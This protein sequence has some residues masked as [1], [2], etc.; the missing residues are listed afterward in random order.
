MSSLWAF[1]RDRIAAPFALIFC[2]F[3]IVAIFARELAPLD[4][5]ETNLAQGLLP[6]SAEHW[7]GTDQFGR[8][9]FSRVILAT[10]VTL[11]ITTAALL[12]SLCIGVPVGMAVGYRGGWL[13][14]IVMRATDMML[15]FPTIMIAI[16]IVVVVG[17]SEKGV[18]IAL[19]LSQLPNFIRIARSA[20]LSVRQE[21]YIEAAIAS[22]ASWP[23]IL[24]KHVLHNIAAPVI[25]KATIAL[26]GFVIGASSLSYLG[27]GVQPPTP[28]WGQML[29]E[30]KGFL[31][32]APYLVIGPAIALSLFVLA[33]NLVGDALNEII[34]P[35]LR[36]R[37]A[38]GS[39]PKAQA[40]D[41]AASLN[42]GAT[43]PSAS[44]T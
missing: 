31:T 34:D 40:D 13:D 35:R 3:Y 5:F 27:L 12:F 16:V 28:E 20:A 8:D 33:A 23:R 37:R 44:R 43:Q 17:P 11:Q 4:P 15:I 38:S 19:G 39:D 22:G 1:A 24:R 30:A 26:P 21:R 10:Q 14:A 25:V 29:N 2:A 41:R 32:R 42:D 6:P 7:F 9:S 36:T 18:I